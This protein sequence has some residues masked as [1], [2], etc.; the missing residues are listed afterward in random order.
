MAQSVG[1][2]PMGSWLWMAKG[3][4]PCGRG[5][6]PAPLRRGLREP[7]L[8]RHVHLPADCDRVLGRAWADLR[9]ERRDQRSAADHA[10]SAPEA[11]LPERMMR[12]SRIARSMAAVVVLLAVAACVPVLA[13]TSA[14]VGR[15]ESAHAWPA[16]PP[17]PPGAVVFIAGDAPAARRSLRAGGRVPFVS[18][19]W[20]VGRAATPGT[21]PSD[22]PPVEPR[23]PIDWPA[24][25]LLPEG[26]TDVEITFDTDVV[27]SLVTLQMFTAVEQRT[28]EPVGEA[29][30]QVDCAL[31]GLGTAPTGRF[32]EE[33]GVG[34][35]VRVTVPT[36][37]GLEL[38]TSVFAVW[39]ADPG[40]TDAD[41]TASYLAR[42]QR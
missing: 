25:L 42:F 2:E 40:G 17:S 18:A 4:T 7:N 36:L 22:P 27:P 38:F 13:S 11:V 23:L 21:A 12:T 6:L 10:G 9:R 1:I 15:T 30:H 35:A 37:G 24:P 41:A 32:R 8:R 31:G 5:E 14:S 3:R 19:D 33:R 34:S 39:T 26:P 20:A 28:G 29:V 16:P